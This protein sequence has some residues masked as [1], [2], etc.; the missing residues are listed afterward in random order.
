M[1]NIELS[2]DQ[3]QTINGRAAVVKIGDS[4][5]PPYQLRLRYCI[6]NNSVYML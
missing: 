5:S 1:P 2:L 4:F 3:L 6:A